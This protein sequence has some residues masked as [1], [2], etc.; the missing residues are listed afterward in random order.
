MICHSDF[1]KAKKADNLQGLS[2]WYGVSLKNKALKN[3]KEKWWL[4]QQFKKNI[5]FYY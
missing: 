2:A 4:D 5:L 3:M 1:V